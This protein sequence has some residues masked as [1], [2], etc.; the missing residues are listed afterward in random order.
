MDYKFIISMI[1]TI[2]GWCMTLGIYIAKLKQHEKDIE[3]LKRGQNE[4][5]NTLN[6]AVQSIN[7]TLIDLNTKMNLLLS[8]KI[9]GDIDG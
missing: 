2:G 9:K 6:T 3:E 5:E 1:V 4:V 8:G 7:N